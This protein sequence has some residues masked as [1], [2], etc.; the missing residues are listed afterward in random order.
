M[1]LTVFGRMIAMPQVPSQF[2]PRMTLSEFKSLIACDNPIFASR[3]THIQSTVP[4]DSGSGS[5]FFIAQL[6]HDSSKKVFVKCDSPGSR[7]VAGEV[8]AYRE[9]VDCGLSDLY[10]KPNAL[11]HNEPAYIAMDFL[12]NPVAT[13]D[14]IQNPR[15]VDLGRIFREGTGKFLAAFLEREVENPDP[16]KWFEEY[17]VGKALEPVVNKLRQVSGPDAD[18]VLDGQGYNFS[19]LMDRDTVWLNGVSIPNGLQFLN[20]LSRTRGYVCKDGVSSIAPEYR[21]MFEKILEARYTA[22]TVTDPNLLNELVVADAFDARVVWVDPGRVEKQ[23][24]LSIPMIKNSGPFALMLGNILR[25]NVRYTENGHLVVKS[26][27]PEQLQRLKYYH[28]MDQIIDRMKSVDAGHNLVIQRPFFKVHLMFMAFRQFIRDMPYSYT[29]NKRDDQRILIDFHLFSLGME[30]M[31]DVLTGIVDQIKHEFPSQSL[32]ELLDRPFH[33]LRLSDIV[34]GQMAR[35]IRSG[36]VGSPE[37]SPIANLYN[38]LF[39]AS[40]TPQIVV[41]D[42]PLG[43]RQL[44]DEGFGVVDGNGDR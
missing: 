35:F 31:R 28:G 6:D 11:S 38:Q 24:Q 42:G 9:L 16:K 5:V 34:D 30:I 2:H 37:F 8:N 13:F 25:G 7:I 23:V 33:R 17:T 20:D 15:H 3:V 10:L 26:E 4:G 12:T 29:H 14:L 18:P 1:R 22:P 32:N 41:Q 44:R 43:Y 19:Q 21:E 27:T 39:V 36:E 40:S